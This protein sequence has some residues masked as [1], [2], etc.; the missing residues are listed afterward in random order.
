MSRGQGAVPVSAKVLAGVT[1]LL[2]VAAGVLGVGAYLGRWPT[3]TWAVVAGVTL[4]G[5]VTGGTFGWFYGKALEEQSRAGDRA[6][7][8]KTEIPRRAIVGFATSLGLLACST[9]ALIA[10]EA[11]WKY[12]IVFPLLAGGLVAL[13][14]GR[15]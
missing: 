1:G 9:W 7:R 10:V 15:R 14:T 5:M 13:R 4:L 11:M 12:A 6:A 3:S 8:P 2:V